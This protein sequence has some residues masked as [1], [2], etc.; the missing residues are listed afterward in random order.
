MASSTDWQAIKAE[1]LISQESLQSLADRFGLS[2]SSLAHR[3]SE[4]NWIGERARFRTEV[5]QETLEVAKE[6]GVEQQIDAVDLLN[7]M[8]RKFLN[9]M[10]KAKMTPFDAVNA[11][12]FRERL[13][14][15]RSG[16]QTGSISTEEIGARWS[17]L[18]F[19]EADMQALDDFLNELASR[20][21]QYN[22]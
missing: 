6:A 15:E 20:H 19:S 8:L 21:K 9:E 22:P 11:L 1:Y 18:G 2:L 5:A 14:A 13:L 3:S 12:R 7:K 17:E 16:Q 4:E 10:D